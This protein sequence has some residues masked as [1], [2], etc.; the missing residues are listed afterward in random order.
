M[1]RMFTILAVLALVGGSLQAQYLTSSNTSSKIIKNQLADLTITKIRVLPS[2]GSASHHYH[3]RPVSIEV[4]IKNIGR[5]LAISRYGIRTILANPQI[6]TV[7]IRQLPVGQSKKLIFK[8][9]VP[10]STKY[11]YLSAGVDARNAVRES[12]ERNN[13]KKIRIKLPPYSRNGKIG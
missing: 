6:H 5:A 10:R 3:L 4:T 12:N 1:K 9:L 2:K 13:S 8:T 11:I 7:S